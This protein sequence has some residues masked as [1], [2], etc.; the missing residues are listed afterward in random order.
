VAAAVPAGV[1]GSLL[2]RLRLCLR[3]LL[4]NSC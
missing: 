3:V 1:V 4:V 2:L